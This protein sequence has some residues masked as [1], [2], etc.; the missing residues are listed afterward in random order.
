MGEKLLINNQPFL[1]AIYIYIAKI[2]Y[3]ELKS[4]KIMCFFEIFQ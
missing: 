3:E 2:L 1:L 4:A